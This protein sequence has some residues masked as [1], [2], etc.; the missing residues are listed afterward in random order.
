MSKRQAPRPSRP[1]MSSQHRQEFQ[2]PASKGNGF[3]NLALVLLSFVSGVFSVKIYEKWQE[4]K[5]VK[6]VL[7]E[8]VAQNAWMRV[9][10]F[11]AP[12]YKA[13]HNKASPVGMYFKNYRLEI[14]GKSQD[15]VKVGP[16]RYMHL[17][18]L[19]GIET[20]KF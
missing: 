7:S 19:E 9:K 4:K 10:A 2:R 18:D 13:P 20:A 6:R 1:S 11:Q 5:E 16:D 15:W 12:I 14:A 17:S 3:A 8:T